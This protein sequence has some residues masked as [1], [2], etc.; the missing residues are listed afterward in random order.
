MGNVTFIQIL[1]CG[2]NHKFSF[3]QGEQYKISYT[4]LSLVHSEELTWRTL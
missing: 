2:E 3:D 4:I 1:K